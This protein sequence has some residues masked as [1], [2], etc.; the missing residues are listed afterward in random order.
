MLTVKQLAEILTKLAAKTPDAP[1][2]DWDGWGIT[3]VDYYGGKTSICNACH[4]QIPRPHVMF[5][6]DHSPSNTITAYMA[7]EEP[8]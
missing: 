7:S 4:Q 3:N 8:S 5:N 2:F 1:V 6:R